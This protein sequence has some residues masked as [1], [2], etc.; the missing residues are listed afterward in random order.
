MVLVLGE[1]VLGE[2][3]QEVRKG[4]GAGVGMLG[5]RDAGGGGI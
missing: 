3:V 2:R 4:R 5:L 1:R